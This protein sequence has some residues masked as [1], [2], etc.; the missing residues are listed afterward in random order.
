MMLYNKNILI[1]LNQIANWLE[2]KFNQETITVDQ[3]VIQPNVEVLKYDEHTAI[4]LWECGAIVCIGSI[5]YFVG[6]DDGNWFVHNDNDFVGFQSAF[7]IGWTSSFI[8]ALERL[9]KYVNNHGTPVYWSDN[10]EKGI[11]YYKL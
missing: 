7:C 5:L 4:S 9:E 11:C 2:S 3:Y 1:K 10:P 6:E 8:A